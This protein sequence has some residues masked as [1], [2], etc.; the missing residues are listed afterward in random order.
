[1]QIAAELLRIATQR[2]CRGWRCNRLPKATL[3]RLQVLEGYL[4]LGRVSELGGGITMCF[5]D[6]VNTMVLQVGCTG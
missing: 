2:L 6:A 4:F 5:T 1:M 3:M